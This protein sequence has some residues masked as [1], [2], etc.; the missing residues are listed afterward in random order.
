MGKHVH[1]NSVQMSAPK[2]LKVRKM[3]FDWREDLAKSRELSRREVDAYGYVLGWLESWRIGKDLA[4]GRDAARRWWTAVAK[5]KE[6]PDWQLRQ[7]GEAIR[8]FLGWLEICEKSGGDARTIGERLMSAVNHA[9]AR[10]G[11]ALKTRETYGGWAARFGTFAGTAARV[12]DETVGREWLTFLVEKEKVAFATQ[13]QALNALVFFYKDVCGRQEVDLQ[14]KMRKTGQRQPVILNKSELMGLIGKL[15]E[16]YKTVALL[17]YGAGLRLKELVQLRVKDVDLERGAVTIHAGKGDKDR[18]SVI[19]SCIKES[20]AKKIE[21]ARDFWEQDRKNGVPGVALPGALARKM[22]RAGEKLAWMWVFPSDHLSEDP[23]SR[24]VRRH[25]LHP[26]VYAEAI[27]R[28]AEEAGIQKRVTTHALRH[29]F[30]TDLLRSGTDI[31]TLQELLGHS[32]VKTT[33]IYAHAAEIGNDRGVRSPLD[34]VEA[35]C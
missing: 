34:R 15:E 29:A 33:E 6:R 1:R 13:K 24:V 22:P 30:A 35:F 28:A 23:E 11:L 18:E 7:W 32:D 14:V 3:R 17:Q 8:W 20:L 25:H 12:M 21:E 31:R 9:G 16:K 10:R 4:A 19:P 27:R 26:K 2:E 5:S